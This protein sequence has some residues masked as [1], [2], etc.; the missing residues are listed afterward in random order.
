M[1]N[2]LKIAFIFTGTILGAG[3]ATGKELVTFFASFNEKGIFSFLFAC[4][5]LSLCC[6]SILGVI[7]K[8]NA[9]TYQD[10]MYSLFGKLGRYIQIFNLA[11]LFVLFSA[12]LAGGGATIHSI[13]NIGSILSIFIFCILTFLA[14]IYGKNAIVSVNTVLCPILIIGGILIG[15]YLQFSTVNV[16]NTNVKSIVSPFVYTSYNAITTIS[17]L[18]SIKHLITSKKIVFFSSLLGGIF[19][20]IIGLSMLMP[21][22][23]NIDYIK[24]E[25]LPILSLINEDIIKNI[26]SATILCA[27]FTTAVSNGVALEDNIKI[28]T[29]VKPMYIKL[30]IIFLGV[31]FSAMGFSKIVSILYPIFGYIGMFE[32]LVIIFIFSTIC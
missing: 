2:I 1:I 14:L 17:V 15:V 22:I 13:F 31:M 23:N 10:F 4:I 21:L 26:Y 16:F 20:F 30:A 9:K 3:F 8:T 29:G 18:F 6:I 12:M 24:N 25:S 28:Y 11:L 32:L 19:I 27:I 5:L 7:Y